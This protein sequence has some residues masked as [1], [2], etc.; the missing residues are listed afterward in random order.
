MAKRV[1]KLQTFRESLAGQI[2]EGIIY[3]AM[4]YFICVYF[5]GNGSFIYEAF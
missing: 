4:L 5:S 1:S 3:A 2:L